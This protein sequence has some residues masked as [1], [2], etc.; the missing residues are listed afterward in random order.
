MQHFGRPVRVVPRYHKETLIDPFQTNNS[1]EPMRLHRVEST[2]DDKFLALLGRPSSDSPSYLKE[3]LKA[4]FSTTTTDESTVKVAQGSEESSDSFAKSHQLSEEESNVSYQVSIE[5]SQHDPRGER[6]PTDESDLPKYTEVI[7]Y[8]EIVKKRLDAIEA[9]FASLVKHSP[10]LD[11]PPH[12]PGYTQLSDDSCSMSDTSHL[13]ALR[14]VKADNSKS[15]SMRTIRA[16][17]K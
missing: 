15:V 16:D 9:G 11:H 10:L 5:L 4:I 3:S 13:S 7:P 2:N 17:Y 1:D 12:R 6:R 14:T 8:R